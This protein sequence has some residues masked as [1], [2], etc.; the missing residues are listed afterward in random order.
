MKT[1]WSVFRRIFAAF[2]SDR[3]GNV[4]ITF[5]FATI[6]LIIAVGSAVDFSRAN[7]VKAAMQAALDSTALMLSKDAATLTQ[8]QM[9]TKAYEYFTSLFTRPEATN[10][11]VGATYSTGTGTSLV[12]N[13]SVDMPTKFMGIVGYNTFHINDSS[14]AKWGYQRLRVALVLDNTGSMNSDGKIGA[15]KTATK[16]LLTQLQ[17]AVG[18]DGD[19]YVSIIPFSKDVNVGSSNFGASWIYWDDAGQTDNNSWDAK[20]GSCSPSGPSPRSACLAQPNCSLTAYT[21]SNS[22]TSNGVCSI[23]TLTSQNTCTC[24]IGCTN[25]GQ[26]TS[27]S[28]TG[29][30]ACTKPQYTSRGS[31]QSNGGIWG[32]GT[33]GA[34]VWTIG[35]WTTY[36]WTPKAHNS[37]NWNGCI[38]DRG[39]TTGP[40]ASNYDQN[41]TAA[42][43]TDD[44]KFPAEQFSGCVQPMMGL[45]YDW[46]AMATMVDNMVATGNTNQPIGLVW[47]WQS[48]VGG[49][50]LT[51]PALD[52]NYQYQQ[53]VILLTDGLN[54]QNRW[55]SSQTSIDNRM[56]DSSGNGT[57]K[58]M[59]AA[60][61]T[62]YTIQVNTGSPGDPVS[63]MLQN[64]ASN[65]FGTTDHYYMLTSADQI[66]T[67]F[68]KIGENLT[69]LRIAY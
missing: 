52:P 45:N 21:D 50:Q 18:V 46:S 48:L 28:C 14:T 69:K 1:R 60:G 33:W 8:D 39:N 16:N 68:N 34:G 31:C 57:C 17:S 35:V 3:G 64:C 4:A 10:I 66:V 5:A 58:N 40:S 27:S 7:S 29:D 61:I 59:K 22:C 13:A 43:G 36:A 30:N 56:Y 9:N 65:T 53:I 51:A 2:R 19:V 24:T 11:V 49:A 41:I 44:S 26:T 37:T 67:T 38:S 55:T 6:P 20:N 12:I 62:I 32:K 15:L 23:S 63:T 47:G 42:G 54:T 25:P